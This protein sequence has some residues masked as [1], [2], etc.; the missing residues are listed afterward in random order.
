MNV[1]IMPLFPTPLLSYEVEMEEKERLFLLGQYPDNVIVNK[2]NLTSKDLNILKNKELKLLE[3]KLLFCINDAF[4]RI[5]TPRHKCKLYITQ[6]WLNF[7]S[8]NQYHHQHHHP[9][10]FL[11]AVLYLRATEG[12]SIVFHQHAYN[13]TYEIYSNDYNMFNSKLWQLPVKENLLLIFPSTL[14]HS[15]PTVTHNNL[16][17]SMSFNT[18]V[19]G[20]LGDPVYL[21][22][23]VL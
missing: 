19:K 3:K 14:P 10:S 4:V 8:K 23:L 6:S 11:S 13:N 16:R 12:D 2:S 21:D 17:V 15:V 5:H 22:H 7:T 18:F 20:Q 1:N 9:N